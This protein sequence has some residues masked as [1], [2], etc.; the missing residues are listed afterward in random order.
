[1]ILHIVVVVLTLFAIRMTVTTRETISK[2]G[3]LAKNYAGDR[4]LCLILQKHQNSVKA[5]VSK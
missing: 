2:D 3:T 5:Y 1:M 4:K